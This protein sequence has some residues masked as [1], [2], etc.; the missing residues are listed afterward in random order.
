MFTF[1][2]PIIAATDFVVSLELSNRSSNRLKEKIVTHKKR[3]RKW[4]N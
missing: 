1:T 2:K 4:G 3:K